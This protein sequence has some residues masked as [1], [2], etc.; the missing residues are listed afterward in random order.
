MPR[1]KL[2][3][4]LRDREP[5]V[6]SPFLPRLLAAGVD[7]SHPTALVDGGIQAL[8]E[9]LEHRG[10]DREAAYLLLAAD[11]LFTY[12]CEALASVEDPS[13]ELTRV[14]H[15]IGSRFEP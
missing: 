15:R 11:A 12:A 7:S 14:V 1:V 5:P 6:P 13:T 8:G 2:E 4:W 10:R 3:A 9:A